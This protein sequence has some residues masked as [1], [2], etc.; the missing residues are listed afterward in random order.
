MSQ[1]KLDCWS[2]EQKRKNKPIARPGIKYFDWFILLLLL[3]TPTMQFYIYLQLLSKQKPY[4]VI[5][6]TWAVSVPKRGAF[7]YSGRAWIGARQKKKEEEEGAGEA[8]GERLPVNPSI[9]KTP[10]AQERGSWLVRR[11]HLDWQVYQIRLTYSRN[12]SSVTCTMPWG[13]VCEIALATA[14]IY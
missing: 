6:L 3:L 8:S 10:F 11:G 13:K 1:W 12:N 5:T 2:R 7:P 4:T 9:L 14:K